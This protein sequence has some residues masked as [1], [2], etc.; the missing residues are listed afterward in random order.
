TEVWSLKISS[1]KAYS[2]N[3]IFSKLH[4]PKGAE[5]YIF[6]EDGSMVYGPVTERQ[7]QH[8]KTYLTDI[9]QG[10][11]VIIQ[12]SV[13]PM[14]MEKPELIIQNVIH[15]YKNI[16]L[17]IGYG[18]SGQCN[19]DVVC[20]FP[21]WED[22]ADGVVQILLSDGTEWC[23]GSLLNN[24][25]QDY[26]PFILT[27]FHCIDGNLNGT[28]SAGEIEDAE[29]WLVRFRFRHTT[30]GGSTFA[31]VISYDDTNF[32][33]A[34]NTTDF[35]L[36]ELQDNII[37]DIYSVGAKV[38][39]GWDRTGNTPSHGT[40]V[41]H[42]SGDVMKYAYDEGS[43][44]ETNYGGTTSGQ[45]YWY[46]HL[47]GDNDVGTFEP[48][49]SGSPV[50]DQNSRVVGQLRG[51]N[52]GCS[53]SKQFWHGCFYRSWTENSTNDTRLSNWLDP[54]N[55]GA[56]TLNSIRQPTPVY[57]GVGNLLCSSTNFS[58]T[59]LA[60]GYSVHH[61]NGSNVTFPNG[62][63][64][65]P[66]LVSPN[67][68]SGQGWIEAVINT[69]GGEYTMERQNFW[70]GKP[71]NSKISAIVMMG[72]SDNQLCRNMD[73]TIAAGHSE[74]TTQRV[75][76]FIWDFGAWGPY[77]QYFDIGGTVQ[78]SRPVFRLTNDA[79]ASQNIKIYAK[80]D[81][82]YNSQ[83]YQKVFYAISC[84]GY[85]LAISPNPATGETTLS[86][87]SESTDATAILTDWDYEIYDSM[88]S[89]KEKKTKLKA[90][91]TKVNTTSWKDGVYIVRAKIGDEVITEKLIVKH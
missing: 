20:Y 35:A 27:A 90:A 29:E 19:P 14:S 30:C 11:S 74:A 25:A 47:N 10:E 50:F 88:Q 31:N 49:S 12:L 67:T 91:Q 23:S 85:Y 52:P 44:L 66:V 81:C 3:F 32:R 70:V 37:N 1:P 6:N 62:N 72:P 80:N 69:G 4:L 83:Y 51:G 18:E 16:F 24:T 40:Y 54:G 84:G 60:P 89:L 56:T 34:C 33:A 28:L 2:L 8:G 58:V 21:A 41:H 15:G 86:L 87:I 39:L 57:S 36:V 38:W 75:T 65:N 63:T 55:T 79:P 61:W 48:G 71:Q 59:T 68:T 42:P 26:R 53:S 64:S 7:N 73:M 5:L 17:D 43:L 82:D 77:F 22:E 13:P 78:D 76:K 46:T 9:I 45:N